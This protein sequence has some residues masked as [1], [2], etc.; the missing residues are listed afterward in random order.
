MIKA[1]TV[2][3]LNTNMT[4][5]IWIWTLI[6][7]FPINVAVKNFLNGTLKCPQVIPAKSNNGFG[8]EAPIKIV[9]KPYFWRLSYKTIFALSNNVLF[10]F[11]LNYWT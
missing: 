9:I 3:F 4:K 2:Y 1:A 5:S 8:T 10:G 7:A 6:I 11:Y